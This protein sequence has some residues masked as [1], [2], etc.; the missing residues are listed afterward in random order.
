MGWGTEN[1]LVSWRIGEVRRRRR[2]LGAVPA[3]PV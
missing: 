3:G 2:W 1:A